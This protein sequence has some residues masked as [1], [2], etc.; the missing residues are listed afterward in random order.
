MKQHLF[1]T[2]FLA[3][4][5]ACSSAPQQT[6][7]TPPDIPTLEF[8]T[9]TLGNGLDVIVSE[10]HRLP[11]VAVNLWYHVGPANEDPGRT[12]FA[13]LFEHMMFQGSKH[14]PG[15]MHFKTV[16]G[17]GGSDFN[18]TTDFDRTNYFETMPADRLETALWLESDRMGYL[19]DD[20]DQGKLSNQQD[21]VR[22]ERR[23][24]VENAPYGIVEEALFHQL[25]P[26]E[27]PYYASVIGSHADIQAAKLED[28]KNFFKLYYAPNNASLVIVGDIDKAATRALVEKY[29]GPLK[30]GAPVPKPSVQTVQTPPITSER[31]AVVTDRVE[32]PRVYM[33]WLTSPI[34]EPGDADAH[35]AASVLG[36][37]RSSRL[38]KKLVYEQQ[39]AQQVSVQQY[40]LTLG[41]VFQ[42]QATARP[43]HTAE[44]LEQSLN[45]ELARF[46]E[47][48][49]DAAEVDRARNGI[50]TNIVQGLERL[51][52]FSGIANRL[53][54]YNHF[55]GNPGYLPQD[56]QRYRDVTP[57]SVKA[58]AAAELAPNA[59]VVVHGVP[60]QP[61]FGAPVP[62]PAPVKIAPG[63]GAES[64]NAAAAWRNDPPKPGA[65][66]MLTLPVPVSFQLANGLTVLVNERPGLPVVSANLVIRSGSGA[67][68]TDRPGLANFT[69]AMLDEGTSS[70]TAPMIADQVAQLGASLTTSSNM[71]ATQIT[72]SSLG[73]NFPALLDL[74]ADVTRHPGFP[75]EEVDRQ[76]ASR[77]GTL[78]QQRENAGAVANSAMFAALY[79]P[80]H[81]YGYVDLGTEASNKA[82]TRDDMRTFWS[83]HF[84]PNNAALVVSGAITAAS[85]RPDVEKAFG[86]WPRGAPAARPFG[87]PATT[88]ARLVIVDKP[89]APQTQVRV[90]SI[91]APRST[92]DYEALRVMNEAL[93]GLF[94]SRI[95]LNLR[96][97]HG[98]TYGASSQFVF[99]RS[100]GP[101]L[102]QSGVRTDATAPAVSEILKEIRR[103]R[104]TPMSADELT[105]AKDSL[106]RSLPSDFQTSGD[107]TATTTNIYLFD[108]GLD[109]FRTY[110]ARLSAVTLD[111]TSEVAKRYLVPEK[112][113][114]VAVGDRAK[115]Q[116]E[117][118]KLNLGALE[119]RSPDATLAV[120][121]AGTP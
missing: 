90:A 54:T 88:A 25:F 106:V 79:G 63:T 59:R 9:F 121:G 87:D 65:P 84:V 118:Q 21:V 107:V 72:G 66:R 58:F 112:L 109:Y 74:M 40:S 77:L 70:R 1:A 98:Y 2:C 11:L 120:R 55:L 26:K 60:G 82:M 36:T 111:Q 32:L 119:L 57:A 45:E 41:S 117:L 51:G 23:Q 69:A 78:A 44:E 6:A 105:M 28:V 114:V 12:G 31:R 16:E 67:N 18:G 43:G 24:S 35:V 48:G 94:S 104:E 19:L 86:D 49:P 75:E 34:F 96:E 113:I 95:N 33:A 42:I 27:H 38:Y 3:A 110:P 7:E 100:A 62:T 61:D 85:L 5:L 30:R 46:R 91:G 102:V 68:P 53:N 93:G 103:M 97:E 20:L 4:S 37:G 83:E 115:I 108:L 81:P 71:D 39:I 50:E 89:G 116:S 64:V 13:H 73:R 15:D 10:D 29:F 52:G 80:A 17:A 76:R 56:V 99:R 47:S 14:A 101:F 92:P 22:N 8:E